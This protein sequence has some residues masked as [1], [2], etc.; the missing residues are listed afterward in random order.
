MGVNEIRA[1]NIQT[2][3]NIKK[4]VLLFSNSGYSN[5]LQMAKYLRGKRW[6]F[7]IILI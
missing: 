3:A 7:M 5:G 6:R 1:G 2:F 4:T